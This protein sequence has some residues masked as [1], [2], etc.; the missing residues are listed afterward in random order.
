ML[1]FILLFRLILNIFE[2]SLNDIG[3]FFKILYIFLWLVIRNRGG[4]LSI[5]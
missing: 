1:D 5:W 3:K 2:G 4:D